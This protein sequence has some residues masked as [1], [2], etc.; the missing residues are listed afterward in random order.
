MKEKLV[1]LIKNNFIYVVMIIAVIAGAFVIGFKGFKYDLNHTNHQRLEVILNAPYDEKE[2]DKAIDEVYK[3]RHI[4]RKSSIFGT[5]VAIDGDKFTDK[6]VTTIL[7]K[8]NEKFGTKYSL[9]NLKLGDIISEYELDDISEMKDEDINKKI[10]EIKKKYN[11]EYTKE[12]LSDTSS[13]KVDLSDVKALDINIMN[14]KSYFTEIVLPLG[15]VVLLIT[16][17]IAVRGFKYDK[18]L[19]I[20]TLLKLAIFEAFL[21]S[22]VAI[23]RLE[24]S[25]FVTTAIISLGILDLIILNVKNENM[26]ISKKPDKK[27][28]K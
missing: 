5:T 7:N 26:I 27:K 2:M 15:I 8:I 23:L 16:L 10:E 19:F 18:L 17:F 25:N 22:V 13:I 21:V 1:N 11:L 6:Q 12:E 4:V 20:K 3:D 24:L 28:S 9:K 14:L